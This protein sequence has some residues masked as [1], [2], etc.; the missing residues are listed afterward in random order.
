MLS[1]L[2][3]SLVFS[4]L[5]FSSLG[6]HADYQWGFGNVSL[7]YLDWDQQTED[8][9]TKKDF[10]F[11]EIEGGAQ[12]S[13]GELYGFFDLEEV[14]K[15]GDEVRTASKGVLRY[16]LGKS[17]V[18]IYAHVYDF[19]A[20]GFAEQN[21]VLGLGYQLTGETAP[22]QA[23]WFKPFLGFHDVSQTFFNGSNGY[24]AGWIIGYSFQISTQ[25]FLFTDWHEYEFSRK[26]AYAAGNGRQTTSHNGAAAIWWMINKEIT[27]GLQY[28]YANDKLGTE[29]NMGAVI[30]TVKYNF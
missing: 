3:S 22:G 28:R 6:V 2:I 16:Y 5:I 9:S 30:T 14:G 21:R 25:N 8:K 12:H 4:V 19:N 13:W 1:R 26:E 29:G 10:T 7:N 15:T 18:S 23:W 20:A 11:L 24:M 17:N 27:L